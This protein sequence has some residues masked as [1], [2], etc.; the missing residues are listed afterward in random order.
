MRRLRPYRLS[1]V[2]QRIDLMRRL[3]PTV[4]RVARITVLPTDAVVLVC[5]EQLSPEARREAL[6]T[7]QDLWPQNKKLVLDEGDYLAIIGAEVIDE[8][9]E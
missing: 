9:R 8:P 5:Q 3:P 1:P 2:E 7:M 4:E 6:R